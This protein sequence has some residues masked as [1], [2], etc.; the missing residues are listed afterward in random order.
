MIAEL[1]HMVKSLL[2]DVK[3]KETIIDNYKIIK[4]SASKGR[5]DQ[6][7]GT[8]K[9]RKVPKKLFDE[10]IIENKRKSADN[11]SWTVNLEDLPGMPS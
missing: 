2:A 1:N 6:S 11:N 7:Q 4:E 10:D 8:E 3:Q 9:T 5:I